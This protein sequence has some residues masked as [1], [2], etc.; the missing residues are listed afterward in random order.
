VALLVGMSVSDVSQKAIA[1]HGWTD[2]KLTHPV[3]PG[4]TLYAESEVLAKRASKSRPDQGLVTVK[5]RGVKSD[6]T[7]FM[8]FERTVLLPRKAN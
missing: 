5:T 8:E 1:N 6:G 4:D 2:I 3:F 7:V